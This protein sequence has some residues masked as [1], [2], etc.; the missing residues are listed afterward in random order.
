MTCQRL[1]MTK[2][3][4]M[5]ELMKDYAVD[6]GRGSKAVRLEFNPQTRMLALVFVDPSAKPTDRPVLMAKFETKRVYSVG[7]GPVDA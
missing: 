7:G 4:D 1:V 6:I 2:I 3:D 5:L